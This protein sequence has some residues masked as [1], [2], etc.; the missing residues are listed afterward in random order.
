MPQP[1]GYENLIFRSVLENFFPQGSPKRKGWSAR[2]CAQSFCFYRLSDPVSGS[3]CGGVSSC[4]CL[5]RWLRGDTEGH[6]HRNWTP[7]AAV[8]PPGRG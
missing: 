8:C 1:S 7:M 3:V 2:G 6:G 4:C 5:S